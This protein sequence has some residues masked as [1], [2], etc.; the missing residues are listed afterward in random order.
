MPFVNNASSGWAVV[1]SDGHVVG[2]YPS[3]DEANAKA[4]EMGDGYD[5][6]YGRSDG[7]DFDEAL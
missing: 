2:A 7:G 3:E 5:V 1:R 4:Q 6:K